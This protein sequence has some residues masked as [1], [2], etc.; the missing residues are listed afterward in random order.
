VTAPTCP[1]CER[2]FADA[3]ALHQ[4]QRDKHGSAAEFPP[5]KKRRGRGGWRTNGPSITPGEAL[6]LIGDDGSEAAVAMAMELAGYEP[7]A[8]DEFWADAL[9]EHEGRH[10]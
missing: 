7:G 1:E 2:P 3:N 4:H 5:R 9:A 10:P 6:D 8:L